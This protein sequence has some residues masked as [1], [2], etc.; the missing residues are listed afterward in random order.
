MSIRF[1]INPTPTLIEYL[2]P[3][4][5]ESGLTSLWVM[6]EGIHFS[7]LML[8]AVVEAV[9]ERR[10]ALWRLATNLRISSDVRNQ[11][12]AFANQ[13]KLI[14]GFVARSELSYS[15]LVKSLVTRNAKVLYADIGWL[16]REQYD[17]LAKFAS[18]STLGSDSVIVFLPEP[19]SEAVMWANVAVGYLWLAMNSQFT[20]GAEPMLPNRSVLLALLKMSVQMGAMPTSVCIDSDTKR[21]LLLWGTASQICAA[22]ERL[23][24]TGVMGTEDEFHRWS[25]RGIDLKL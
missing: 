22:A 20:S 14:D 21:A 19:L 4:V 1:W 18:E 11:Y 10:C 2:L 6:S 8:K 17:L 15:E 25:S 9:T 3:G 5:Q 16:A 23:S 24:A 12:G 7:P 13:P